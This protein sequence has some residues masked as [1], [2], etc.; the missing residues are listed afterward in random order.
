MFRSARSPS[1]TVPLTTAASQLH[2]QLRSDILL[3]HIEPGTKLVLKGLARCY[4]A[5]LI[6]LR[7]ALNRLSAEGLVLQCDQRGFFVCEISEYDFLDLTQARCWLYEGALRASIKNGASEWED[8]LVLS[9]Y[10]LGELSR[11]KDS[12]A[13]EATQERTT[14]HRRFHTALIAACGSQ[15][16]IALSENMFDQ[17]ERYRNLV[18]LFDCDPDELVDEHRVIMEA[19]LR[20]DPETAVRELLNHLN[21]ACRLMVQALAAR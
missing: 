7:E 8:E 5:G 19:A 18:Q 1:D 20:R 4:K 11:C 2:S 10:R 21:S 16:A 14:A 9:F 17:A 6:P 13:T 3:G 12:D 15:R